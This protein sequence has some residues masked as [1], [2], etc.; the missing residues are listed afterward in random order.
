MTSCV[1]TEDQ[2][3]L[4]VENMRLVPFILCRYYGSLVADDEDFVSMGYIALCRAAAAYNPDC[5]ARFSTFAARSIIN[6]INNYNTVSHSPK[7]WNGMPVASLNFN[8][9]SDDNHEDEYINQLADKRINVEDEAINNVLCDKIRHLCP[10]F[11]ELE[12]DGISVGE[13]ARKRKRCQQ[14]IH[15]RMNQE[16]RKARCVLEHKS[17]KA[18]M[19]EQNNAKAR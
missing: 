10:T 16:F 6:Y 1:L 11:V 8:I 14:G 18:L 7:R 15:R 17:M 4:V 5:K 13:L 9:R 2:Q 19:R 3:K 12:R